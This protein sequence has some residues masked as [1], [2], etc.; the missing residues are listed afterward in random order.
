M[1]KE[2][3][4]LLEAAAQCKRQLA[5]ASRDQPNIMMSASSKRLILSLT[6]RNRTVVVLGHIIV[7]GA[8]QTESKLF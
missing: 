4:S 3:K 6:I 7:V 1:E 5:S 8:G 2:N